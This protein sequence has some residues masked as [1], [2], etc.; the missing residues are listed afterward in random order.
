M[1]AGYHGKAPPLYYLSLKQTIKIQAQVQT[2]NYKKATITNPCNSNGSKREEIVWVFSHISGTETRL[3][4]FCR[5][6]VE[7]T[8]VRNLIDGLFS[9]QATSRYGECDVEITWLA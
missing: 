7:K 2:T 4:S 3:I 6:K 8:A 1:C 9:L 5:E